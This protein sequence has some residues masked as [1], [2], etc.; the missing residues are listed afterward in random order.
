MPNFINADNGAV[1]GSAGVKTTADTSGV[2]A[3]Q[4]NGVTGLTLNTSLN[5][6]IGT[7]SPA[8]KLDVIGVV[9]V[10]EDGA[11]TKTIQLRSDWAGV[12]PAIQVQTNN[13]LLFVTNGS[14]RAR[15][16]S[17]GNFG[18]GTTS[19]NR[20]LS[21]FATQPVFQITN[22]ASGNTQG[23]IQYQASGG[24]D[25][26]LDNQ[27]SGSG[28]NIIFQQA[29]T[30]R[31]RLATA[32][33]IG[34]GG[35]NYGTSGQVLTSGGSGAAPTWSSPP[36]GGFSNIAV[37]TTSG[38]WSVPAGV[39]KCKIT[40]TGGGGAGGSANASNDTLACYQGGGAG[41]TAI[42]VLTLSGGSITVT[43]GAGGTG[44]VNSN[45]NS[46]GNSTA[47]YG[48]T[49]IQGSGGG[50]GSATSVF[51]NG[52][53]ASGGDLNIVGGIGATGSRTSAGADTSFGAGG[54]SF[55]GGGA[56]AMS[57]IS[58]L[59]YGAGSGGR[60]GSGLPVPATAAPG[61]VVIEF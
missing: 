34:I 7:T 20:L 38:T 25:F 26:V 30:E 48:G 56:P 49:T 1:S 58:P 12:D 18:I 39:T 41:G 33:Q 50:G 10:N 53:A 22:V 57:G 8:A 40:V 32:G 46:G 36:A 44:N 4:S 45:G 3:L 54:A 37:F 13:P 21:L 15:I 28:G 19:P 59:T 35:A 55:W 17:G 47:V 24:T 42:G 11:G 31:F 51:N 14:E 52:G 29:G 6:G 61:V 5:V 16:T 9:R 23:T 2:L 60:R 27:G 43:I